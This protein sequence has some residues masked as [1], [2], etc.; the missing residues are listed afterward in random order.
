MAGK[1]YKVLLVDPH[2]IYRAGLEAVLLRHFPNMEVKHAA[3]PREALDFL[4][5]ER[6]NLIVADIKMEGRNGLGILE[7]ARRLDP[8]VPL[9]VISSYPVQPF[10]C[11]AI[12]Q[13]AAGY[14]GKELKEAEL[15]GAVGKILEGGRYISGELALAL[16]DAINRHAE[17]PRHE[18]LSNRELHVLIELVNGKCVKEIASA[19]S[20]SPKTVSTYRSRV[21]EKL[22]IHSDTELVK[23]CI[24]HNLISPI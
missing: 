3:T 17:H 4:G 1:I 23:Y 12:Q 24:K 13:G 2:A 5:R 18:T 11:R 14:M 19:L 6:W 7:E 9:L 10:G 22:G 8:P 21:A 20:L 15:L 16:A